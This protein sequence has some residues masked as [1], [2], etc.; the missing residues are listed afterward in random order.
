MITAVL[1]IYT[2]ISKN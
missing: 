2:T 1:N